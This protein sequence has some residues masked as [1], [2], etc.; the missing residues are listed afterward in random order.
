[1]GSSLPLC[2]AQRLQREL[3]E[4]RTSLH[5]RE[6]D[7]ERV[8]VATEEAKRDLADAESVWRK[9][10][11]DLKIAL[12]EALATA[13]K[14]DEKNARSATH[15]ETSQ[16]SPVMSEAQEHSPPRPEV[17]IDGD[18]TL[19]DESPKRSASGAS[20]ATSR[21]LGDDLMQRLE[22]D[23]NQRCST[24]PPAL[25]EKVRLINDRVEFSS[26]SPA[27]GFIA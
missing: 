23:A 12:K 9:E 6:K 7:C 15:K 10:T 8:T 22:N 17:A 21:G 11:C 1:M 20:N 27:D 16:Q 13:G 2:C 14:K 26:R 25:S 4:A 19:A 18:P 24:G 5:T 3:L